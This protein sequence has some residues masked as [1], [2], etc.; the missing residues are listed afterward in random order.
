MYFFHDC[1][2]WIA[3]KVI[4]IIEFPKILNWKT[5]KKRKLVWSWGKIWAKLCLML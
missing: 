4:N 1:R 3:I 5:A 2:Y